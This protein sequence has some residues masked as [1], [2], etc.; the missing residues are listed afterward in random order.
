MKLIKQTEEFDRVLRVNVKLK[1]FQ[2]LWKNP[3][4]EFWRET[5]SVCQLCGGG[6]ESCSAAKKLIDLAVFVPLR[7]RRDKEEG[8]A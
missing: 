8:E 2:G 3:E 5:Y 1:H 6:R 7:S 4:S